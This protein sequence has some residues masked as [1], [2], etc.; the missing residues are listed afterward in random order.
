MVGTLL[1]FPQGTL[2]VSSRRLGRPT[3]SV[4]APDR[5]RAKSPLT[6]EALPFA[7]WCERYLV[8]SIDQWADKPLELEPFQRE[9]SDEA[10]AE[11]DGSYRWKTL[12]LMLPRKNGKTSL[13]AAYSLF[14][15][16]TDE[17]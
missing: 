17:G 11:D 15:L 5:K 4:S 7:E 9:F 16:L 8:Q 6:L 14:R 3:G 2:K 13:L 1:S 12:V 10:L